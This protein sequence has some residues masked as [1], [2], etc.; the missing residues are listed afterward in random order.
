MDP[1]ELPRRIPHHA[2]RLRLRFRKPVCRRDRHPIRHTL[3]G[4][5]RAPPTSNNRVWTSARPRPAHATLV[6]RPPPQPPPPPRSGPEG[7]PPPP[8]TSPSPP[9]PVP[10]EAAENAPNARTFKPSAA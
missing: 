10:P 5:S 7:P 9:R 3:R 4:I 2:F 1:T 8:P 6:P